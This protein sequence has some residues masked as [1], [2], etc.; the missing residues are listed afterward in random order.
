M[1]LVIQVSGNFIQIVPST[2]YVDEYTNLSITSIFS[3]L[4]ETNKDG[5]A[6]LLFLM[7][8]LYNYRPEK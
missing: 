3:G 8:F 6:R 5:Y 2:S 4:K 7:G 1:I